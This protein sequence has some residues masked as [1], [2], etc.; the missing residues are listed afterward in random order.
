[1]QYPFELNAK[2]NTYWVTLPVYTGYEVTTHLMNSSFV[3]FKFLLK[4][5]F[6]I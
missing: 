2:K 5:I 1:M 6:K 4:I 3:Q